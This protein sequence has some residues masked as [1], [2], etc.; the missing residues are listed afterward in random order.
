MKKKIQIA[1]S[2]IKKDQINTEEDIDLS[3]TFNTKK[4][5]LNHNLSE[6]IY[7]KNMQNDTTEISK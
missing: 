7:D 2:K 4:Q 6:E 5:L 1:N 3:K